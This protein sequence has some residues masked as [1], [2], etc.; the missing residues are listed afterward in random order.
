[1]T[2]GVPAAAEPPPLT[3]GRRSSHAALAWLE[4]LVGAAL[5]VIGAV[6]EQ[7]GRA[8]AGT[9]VAGVTLVGGALL[10]MTGVIGPRLF[11]ALSFAGGVVL[12]VVAF[13]ASD[14]DVAQAGLL[15]ASAVTFLGAFGSLASSRSLAA[16]PAA[17]EP[18]ASVESV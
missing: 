16:H 2:G 10:V 4:V 11:A 6:T 3:R 5:V 17:E 15:V 13:S 7:S 8:Q 14:F 12:G 18:S 1:M 9:I